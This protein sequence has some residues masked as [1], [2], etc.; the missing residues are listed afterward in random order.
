MLAL[1]WG[2]SLAEDCIFSTKPEVIIEIMPWHMTV[3]CWR[4]GGN[5][6]V[7]SFV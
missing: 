4:E 2:R 6:S 1:V 7:F 5:V 3:L